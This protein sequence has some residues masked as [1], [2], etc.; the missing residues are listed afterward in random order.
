[1]DNVVARGSPS[2]VFVTPRLAPSDQH[3][4]ICHRLLTRYRFEDEL[5]LLHTELTPE[6]RTTIGVADPREALYS[7]AVQELA[8]WPITYKK[9]WRTLQ[10]SWDALCQMAYA[11]LPN[12]FTLACPVS[13][14]EIAAKRADEFLTLLEH[15]RS[16]HAD[17][18]H[19]LPSWQKASDQSDE[20]WAEQQECFGILRTRLDVI[21]ESIDRHDNLP[22]LRPIYIA[23]PPGCGKSF[24]ALHC[25][26]YLVERFTCA[27]RYLA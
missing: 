10:T 9:M 23:G 17:M 14:D 5:P 24:L 15:T 16:A 19:Y 21:L 25:L 7:F 26:R 22:Y 20:S 13:D 11:H 3:K 1:M 18:L 6:V 2:R 27:S 4:Y 12:C 8:Y